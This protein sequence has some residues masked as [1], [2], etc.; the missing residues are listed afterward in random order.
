MA[1]SASFIRPPTRPSTSG[2]APVTRDAAFMVS[3]V[4]P[5]SSFGAQTFGFQKHGQISIRP[6]IP[7]Q[8]T[9][10]AIKKPQKAPSISQRNEASTGAQNIKLENCATSEPV[11]S[12]ETE[13]PPAAATQSEPI[14][15]EPKTFAESPSANNETCLKM[16]SSAEK[17]TPPNS[18][19]CLHL[20]TCPCCH[21]KYQEL[22]QKYEEL[23]NRLGQKRQ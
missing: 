15:P 12:R 13:E 17:A 6:P 5:P 16:V 20:D 21:M 2:S 23:R 14:P 4:R 11:C 10:L 3:G 19:R 9:G 22:L 18:P 8:K 7:L 1:N